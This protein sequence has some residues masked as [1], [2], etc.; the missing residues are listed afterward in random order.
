MRKKS[1]INSDES[2]RI[3]NFDIFIFLL[4]I[5]GLIN[6]VVHLTPLALEIKGV[7]R[8]MSNVYCLFFLID[9]FIRLGK[10]RPRA[11]Y[12][13][14]QFGFLDL[15]GSVPFAPLTIFRLFRLIKYAGRLRQYT[16]RRL[17]KDINDRRPESAFFLVFIAVLIVLEFGGALVLAA[18]ANMPDHN[19]KTASDALWWGMTTIATVGYGDRYPVSNPGRIIGVIMMLVGVGTFG[20]LTSFLANSL[21]AP[22]SLR[23]K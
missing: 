22:K 8:V 4:T 9:F 20:V 14:R 10:S 3:S 5:L 6:L 2:D 18:E 23:E 16:M 1:A 11:D 7:F 15:L 19:I 12:V 17:V 21:L 13:L